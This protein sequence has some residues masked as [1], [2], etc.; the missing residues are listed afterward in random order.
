MSEEAESAVVSSA[1]TKAKE[2][3][4][5]MEDLQRTVI[6]SKDSAIRSARSIQHNSSSQ[7][8]SLQVFESV[9]LR[10]FSCSF[11]TIFVINWIIA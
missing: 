1:P 8:R 10:F 7:F 3:K 6:E 11:S 5:W 4:E 9:D 2:A